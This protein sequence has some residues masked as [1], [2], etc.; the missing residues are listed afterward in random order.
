MGE[1][2]SVPP[3]PLHLQ[4]AAGFTDTTHKRPLP[5]NVALQHDQQER[6][7]RGGIGTK[8]TCKNPLCQGALVSERQAHVT[9][10]PHYRSAA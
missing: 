6:K 7:R 4:P 5:A 3:L 9:T 10:C 8:K 2:A 1:G